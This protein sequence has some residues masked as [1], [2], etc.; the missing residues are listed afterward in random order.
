MLLRPITKLAFSISSGSDAV[1]DEL[2]DSNTTILL[3][4]LATRLRRMRGLSDSPYEGRRPPMLDF[5]KRR[6]LLDRMRRGDLYDQGLVFDPDE[7]VHIRHIGL[8]PIRDPYI[9]GG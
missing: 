7:D 6:D 8:Y 9:Y 3:K 5:Y 2:H 4:Q 1:S